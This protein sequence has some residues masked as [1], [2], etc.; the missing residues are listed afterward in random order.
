MLPYF[1]EKLT[2]NCW[3]LDCEA[4]A[5]QEEEESP[6]SGLPEHLFHRAPGLPD[7]HPRGFIGAG[8]HRPG[9]VLRPDQ[10]RDPHA[11]LRRRE[12][13]GRRTKGADS[14]FLFWSAG[15]WRENSSWFCVSETCS[16]SLCCRHLFAWWRSKTL[17]LWPPPQTSS[18]E[19][20]RSLPQ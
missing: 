11:L 15:S 20:R 6:D 7:R 13:E 3:F 10:Q 4:T 9:Q 1:Y 18:S 16:L 17:R 19:S 12:Q 5:G 2:W 14:L 8:S